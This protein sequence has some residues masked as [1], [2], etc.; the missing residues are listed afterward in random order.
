VL[1]TDQNGDASLFPRPE[2]GDRPLF[3]FEKG[4][5]PFFMPFANARYRYFASQPCT[6]W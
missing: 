4:T 6:S 2:K 5:V 1:N 3:L